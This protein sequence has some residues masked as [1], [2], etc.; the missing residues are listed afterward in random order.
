M[1]R[2]ILSLTR[3][4]FRVDVFRPSGSGGQKMQKTSSG[5]RV[6]HAPSGASGQATDTR[7]QAKNKALAFRRMYETDKFQTWFRVQIAKALDQ[8]TKADRWEAWSQAGNDFDKAL[9]IEYYENGRWIFAEDSPN[10]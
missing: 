6:S 9:K 10:S 7:D 4:D 8:D 3:K 2:K 1:R 5:V